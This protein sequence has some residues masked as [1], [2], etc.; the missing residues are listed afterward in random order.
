[1]SSAK[2]AAILSR[3]R[4]VNPFHFFRYFV[5]YMAGLHAIFQIDFTTALHTVWQFLRIKCSCSFQ[6]DLL[7][8]KDPQG[9]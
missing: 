1:M 9:W 8:S 5:M 7:H 2:M 3:G 4:W 6:K